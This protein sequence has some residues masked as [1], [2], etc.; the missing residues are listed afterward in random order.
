MNSKYKFKKYNNKI[1]LLRGGEITSGIIDEKN[2]ELYE[3]IKIEEEPNMDERP[4]MYGC[5]SGHGRYNSGN[6]FCVIP[7][8]MTIYTLIKKN[9]SLM[10]NTYGVPNQSEDMLIDYSMIDQT[11]TKFSTLKTHADRAKNLEKYGNN[12]YTIYQPGSVIEN[13]TINFNLV[14]LPHPEYTCSGIITTGS[15]NDDYFL[16]NKSEDD[17]NEEYINDMIGEHHDTDI[18]DT[19]KLREKVKNNCARYNLS[20]ILKLINKKFNSHKCEILLIA[21]RTGPNETEISGQFFEPICDREQEQRTT[22]VEY[23]S[24]EDSTLFSNKNFFSDLR[25][26]INRYEQFGDLF[27]NKITTLSKIYARAK[28]NCRLHMLDYDYIINS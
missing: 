16:K 17:F 4:K 8:N 28:N 20:Y 2:D 15:F 14:F 22:T 24:R 27:I 5:I 12:N 13:L 23:M 11:K 26:I 19:D 6:G 21:C 1:L 7:E 10:M 25:N 9:T 3:E 18:I